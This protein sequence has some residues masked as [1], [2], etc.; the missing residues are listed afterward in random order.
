MATDATQSQAQSVSQAKPFLA[1][2]SPAQSNLHQISTSSSTAESFMTARTAASP[3]RSSPAL[4]SATSASSTP[5]PS[6]STPSPSAASFIYEIDAWMENIGRLVGALEEQHRRRRF[7]LSAAKDA[8]DARQLELGNSSRLSRSGLGPEEQG[9]NPDRTRA[10]V[11]SQ[12]LFLLSPLPFPSSTMQPSTLVL[13]KGVADIGIGVILF[14]KPAFL[15][16]SFATRGLSSL[17]GLY[18]TNASVAPGFNHSIAC[19]VAA[20]GVGNLVAAR[21][22][23]AALPPICMPGFLFSLAGIS[24]LVHLPV[25][26]TSAWSAFSLFTCVLAPKSWGVS[27]ATLLMGGLVNALFSVGLYVAEPRVFRL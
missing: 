25:A 1:L 12:Q 2:K 9:A 17:T 3:A 23:P 16:E 22:G 7:G 24:F 4:G 15:Y 8:G 20:V 26:M 5:S 21:A 18:M 27:G 6:P 19:M 14:T 11:V 13:C 10:T